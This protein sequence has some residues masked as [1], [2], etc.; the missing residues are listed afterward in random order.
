MKSK[1]QRQTL[2]LHRPDMAVFASLFFVVNSFF[3][4]PSILQRPL[5]GLVRLAET[6]Y[7]VGG[8]CFNAPNHTQIYVCLTRN[9]RLS[10]AASDPSTQRA[11]LEE[12]CRKYGVSLSAS[13]AA[14][15]SALSFVAV[16]L[17]KLLEILDHPGSTKSR[18]EKSVEYALTEGQLLN[19]A[20]SSRRLSLQLTGLPASIFLSIDSQT[21]ASLAIRLVHLLQQQNI[22]QLQLLTHYD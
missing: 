3:L 4:L 19:C 18:A 11:S 16:K 1:S 20:V 22:S 7:L 14:S 2:C 6:P 12:T 13:G 10:F 8:G 15:L 21:N 5:R 17:E 9:G